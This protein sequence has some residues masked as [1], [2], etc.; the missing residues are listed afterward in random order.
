MKTLELNVYRDT[1]EGKDSVLRKVRNT[2]DVEGMVGNCVVEAS[3]GRVD[4]DARPGTL[5]TPV[6]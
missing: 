3:C 2:S 6:V 1:A 4:G 5:P